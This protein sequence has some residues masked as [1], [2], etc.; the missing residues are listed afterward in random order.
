MGFSLSLKSTNASATAVE[1]LWHEVG[2]FEDAPSMRALDYPPH[3]TF[4]VYDGDAVSEVQARH[5]LDRASAGE[6]KVGIAFDRMR[7][8]AGPPLVLW[9]APEPRE[10]LARMHQAIHAAI[11]P[12]LC[13]PHY[14]PGAWTPHCTLGMRIRDE[15]R[16]DA[17]AFAKSF[18][19]GVAV[20]FD[21]IDVMAFPP[22]RLVA[23][24]RLSDPGA[25]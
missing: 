8:F 13:R 25:R 7:T 6:A 23:E 9:L 22:L 17:L 19:G 4:A 1:A 20:V 3:V 2:A 18:R 16:D 11:D 5:A 10:A 14:R 24:R 21:A 15:R 12:A